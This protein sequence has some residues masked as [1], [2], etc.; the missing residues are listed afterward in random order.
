MA[1]AIQLAK[2][3]GPHLNTHFPTSWRAGLLKRFVVLTSEKTFALGASAPG[4]RGECNTGPAHYA[5][6]CAATIR[7]KFEALVLMT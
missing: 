4:G 1:L 7:C 6:V 3:V 5:R 2:I